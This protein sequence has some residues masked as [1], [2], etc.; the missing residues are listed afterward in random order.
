M[1]Q[2]TSREVF[3]F[4]EYGRTKGGIRAALGHIGTD[5]GPFPISDLLHLAKNWRSRMM[6]FRLTVVVPGPSVANVSSA[7]IKSVIETL[8]PRPSLTDES[9]IGKMTDVYPISIFRFENLLTL[10]GAGKFT[11]VLMLLPMILLL[12]AVRVDTFTSQRSAI[13]P[14]LNTRLHHHDVFSSIEAVQM[15]LVR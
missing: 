3:Q 6:K 4:L 9:Q 2:C 1:L 5:G 7:S 15:F 12:N 14:R 10:I 13:T 11:K 8:G